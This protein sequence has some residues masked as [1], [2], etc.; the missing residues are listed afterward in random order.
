M[1]YASPDV[2]NTFLKGLISADPLPR[3]TDMPMKFCLKHEINN[4]F[5]DDIL[6]GKSARKKVLS[7]Y[8]L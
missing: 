3:A 7:R 4:K 2:I 5:N 6:P 8:Y 1:N